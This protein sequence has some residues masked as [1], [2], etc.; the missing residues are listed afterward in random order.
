MGTWIR[1]GFE[2]CD[3]SSR[4]AVRLNVRATAIQANRALAWGLLLSPLAQV[5][6]GTPFMRGLLFDLALLA[7]HA[8]LSLAL[9]GL[10][11]AVGSDDWKL[12]FGFKP[13][14]MG[15]RSNFLMTGWRIA[16]VAPYSLLTFVGPLAWFCWLPALW[17]WLRL[18]FSAVGHI[19]AAIA[20]AGR[21]W[22]LRTEDA[23]IL[24]GLCAFIFILA[25]IYNL[26]R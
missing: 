25:S 8:A 6:M 16:L 24:G 3:C 22:R 1:M 20:Y 17:L 7:A 26:L 10:P 4:P 5:A 11:K 19:A 2:G 13:K 9:F 15:P 23:W 12:W 18:P 14:G 21:R